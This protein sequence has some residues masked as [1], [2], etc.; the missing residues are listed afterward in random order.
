MYW[1]LEQNVFTEMQRAYLNA[2]ESYL[3]HQMEYEARFSDCDG[4]SCRILSSA[5]KTSQI[6]ITGVMTK[7]P[8]FMAAMF[9]GGNTTYAEIAAAL[10]QAD[11]DETTDQIEILMDSGGGQ[12][13]G[14]F[15]AIAA[16][17]QTKKPINTVV[18]GVMASAAYGIGSQSDTVVAS[19]KASRV[20]SIGVAATFSVSDDK[21]TV[22]SSKAPKKRPDVSTGE[23]VAMVQEELNAMHDL[24]VDTIAK[25]RGVD[26]EKV[27]ADFGQGATLLADEAL[28]RGMIDSIAEE[29]QTNTKQSASN[30]GGN[31]E[32]NSMNLQELMAQHPEAYAAAVEVGATQERTRVSAHLVMAEATG[33]MDVAMAAIES[34]ECTT[35]PLI[36]AKYQA[37]G[38]KKQAVAAIDGDQIDT[39]SPAAPAAQTDADKEHEQFMAAYQGE[40]V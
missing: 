26:D 7:S 36:N 23:G 38:L 25:G 33:A 11:A 37:A 12:F 10:A 13:D 35:N 3:Q 14:L 32:V 39:G 9:G 40:D 34:G 17:Q 2:G 30:G 29:G 16:M 5:G 22:T 27:N 20:G 28:K 6:K 18:T 15:N 1:L 8:N 24:F 19:D 31:Q 4:G 21:V